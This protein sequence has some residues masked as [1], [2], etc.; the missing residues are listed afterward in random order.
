MRRNGPAK[1]V[2][3]TGSHTAQQV[4]IILYRAK[5]SRLQKAGLKPA[6]PIMGRSLEVDVACTP[7]SRHSKVESAGGLALLG[8][9]RFL[10]F[11]HRELGR[12]QGAETAVRSQLSR[13]D[14]KYISSRSENTSV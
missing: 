12:R 3:K 5:R 11:K 2:V 10:S 14:R 13:P 8:R 6:K 9:L 1:H 4:R 7:I